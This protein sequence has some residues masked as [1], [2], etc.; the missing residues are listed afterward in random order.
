VI[1][2]S[3]GLRGAQHLFWADVQAG[4]SMEAWLE[5][6]NFLLEDKETSAW[7]LRKRKKM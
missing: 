7:V 2:R 5:I 6:L 3:Y 4:S 1:L